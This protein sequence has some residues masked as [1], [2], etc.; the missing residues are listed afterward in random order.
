MWTSFTFDPQA[1]S[2]GDYSIRVVVTDDGNPMLSSDE[3]TFE[4]TLEEAEVPDD[5]GNDEGGADDGDSDDGDSDGGQ[6]SG[7]G[8]NP[9]STG[10]GS[11]GGSSGGSINLWLLCLLT[12]AGLWRRRLIR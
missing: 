4:F 9:P 12:L 8:Q 7:G 6:D 1:M 10:G 2:Q 11:S 3:V 5:G